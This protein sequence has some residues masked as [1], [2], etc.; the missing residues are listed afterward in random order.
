[1]GAAG[2]IIPVPAFSRVFLQAAFA[3]FSQLR[4]VHIR[5]IRAEQIISRTVNDADAALVNPFDRSDQQ[6]D[7]VPLQHEALPL[8]TSVVFVLYHAF[9]KKTKG[10]NGIDKKEIKINKSDIVFPWETTY[11]I[12]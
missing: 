4:G 3:E 8:R 7:F 9:L 6:V 12:L 11:N 2:G 5:K 1:M 10:K